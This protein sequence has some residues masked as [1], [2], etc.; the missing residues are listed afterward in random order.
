MKQQQKQQKQIFGIVVS[1]LIDN[2]WYVNQQEDFMR[3]A[4]G[5]QENASP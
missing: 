1:Y 4:L 2:L 5:H 3:F